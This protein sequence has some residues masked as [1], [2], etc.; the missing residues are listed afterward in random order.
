MEQKKF[1]VNNVF[2]GVIGIATLM[3]AIMGA[4]FAYFTATAEN[5]ATIGGNMA[6]V[7]MD[8][9]ITKM[10]KVDETKGG[11]IP[12]SNNMIEQAIN[13]NG[14]QICVDDNGNA[15]CQ[16]YKVTVTNQSSSS[17]FVDGYVTLSGGSGV[18]VD[19]TYT[20]N[21]TGTTM[22]WAQAFCTA[23]AAG[24]VTA[25]S[26]AGN[27]TVRIDADATMISY[28]ALGGASTKENGTN[29]A[30]IKTTRADIVNA[31]AATNAAVINGNKYEAINKN[32]IRVSDHT[33]DS[34]KYN[35]TDDTTSALV[36]N[37][38]L[39]AN[40]SKA[41]AQTGNS[42]G[43]Y[44]YSQVYYIVVWLSENG[45]NQT[46]GSGGT[47]VPSSNLGFFKGNATF[48]TAQGNEVTATFSG[49]TRVAP[50]TPKA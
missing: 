24:V 12:M 42:N 3:V 19:H 45:K 33:L 37:Q 10:T 34:Y 44:T 1:N 11:L 16:I 5:T 8:V 49:H 17:M 29:T 23:E 39:A 2:Y 9:V 25:C 7:G 43:T 46:A 38:Y 13:K 36:Y 50:D 18:P 26:T 48:I 21:T 41:A 15:V 31:Q 4:T 27:S 6:T 35:R 47:N 22:R 40:A 20:K 14:N 30:E 32:F 28:S